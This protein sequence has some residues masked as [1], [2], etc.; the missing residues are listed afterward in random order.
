[1]KVISFD[2][3]IRN[4]A[5]CL[6]EYI[7][8][9]KIIID[10]NVINILPESEKCYLK[11]CKKLVTHM[12]HHND[13]PIY[14]CDAHTDYYAILKGKGTVSEQTNVKTI[15]CNTISTDEL[16]KAII[17]NLNTIMMPLLDNSHIDHVLI[18]NQPVIKN[19]KMKQVMDTIYC[20]FLVKGMDYHCTY[21][22]H[23]ISPSNKLKQYV[24]Q[25]TS[26]KETK[27]K[28]VE[29]VTEFITVNNRVKLI[30]H[31]SKFT[32]KDDLCD[33]LLQGFY[34]IDKILKIKK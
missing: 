15:N 26:Y 22:V 18:E 27:K 11:S 14:W 2:V 34:W 7:D 1:M 8:N 19:P 9:K 32:K 33:S 20:W 4:L 10:W 29:V 13:V 3:G 12:C 6:I 16:R 28:S 30:N 5:Y 17:R 23:L 24:E 21:E 31:L 25:L